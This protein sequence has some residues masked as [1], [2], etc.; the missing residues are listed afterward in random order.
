MQLPYLALEQGVILDR[1]L[2]SVKV[3]AMSGPHVCSVPTNFIQKYLK[4]NT[5]KFVYKITKVCMQNEENQ[6]H[7]RRLF[8]AMN[9]F[10]GIFVCLK[11]GQ[12]LSASVA[13]L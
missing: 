4:C 1:E 9:R 12:G 10:S 8:F 5:M 7:K 3:I 13:L 6:G 2:L 11:Q